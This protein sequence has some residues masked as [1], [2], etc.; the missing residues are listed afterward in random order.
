MN[1]TQRNILSILKEHLFYATALGLSLLFFL[2][3]GFAYLIIGSYLPI[4]LISA[5][6]ILFVLSSRKSEKSFKKI[7]S[8][9]AILLIIWSSVRLLLSLVNQFVK[10]IPESHVSEQLGILSAMLSLLFLFGAIYLLS[11]KNR[12]L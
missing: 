2:Y 4:A 8:I 11:Y 12:L 10:P 5:I 7:I 9:W 1:N 6:V 3:K